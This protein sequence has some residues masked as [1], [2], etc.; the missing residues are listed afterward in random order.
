M[1]NDVHC[2]YFNVN[3]ILMLYL[4]FLIKLVIDIVI[5]ITTKNVLKKKSKKLLFK[6]D[7]KMFIKFTRFKITTKMVLFIYWIKEYGN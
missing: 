4:Q 1:D 5:C 7:K 3:T 2:G 6:F